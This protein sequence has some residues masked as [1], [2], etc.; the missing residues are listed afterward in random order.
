MFLIYIFT[1]ELQIKRWNCILGGILSYVVG[2]GGDHEGSNGCIFSPV[3]G[4]YRDDLC[5]FE[6]G[7]VL[8]CT[9][10]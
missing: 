6:H 4:F 8:E 1:I 5:T 3:L 10:Y 9:C 7:C 2:P